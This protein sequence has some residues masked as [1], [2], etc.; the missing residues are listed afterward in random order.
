MPT[1]VLVFKTPHG[2]RYERRHAIS[3]AVANDPAERAAAISRLAGM[4]DR[5]VNWSVEPEEV[6]EGGES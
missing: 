2:R 3:E 4:G 1:L 5:L 6:D